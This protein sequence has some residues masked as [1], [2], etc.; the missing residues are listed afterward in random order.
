MIRNFIR[1]FT[2]KVLISFI[3]R[4]IIGISCRYNK[5]IK[6]NQQYIYVANHNSHLDTACILCALSPQELLST[7]PV[8][9]ADYFGKNKLT[10][11]LSEYFLNA[12]LIRRNKENGGE[13]PIEKMDKL[14]KQGKSLIIFPEGSRGEP[15]KFQAFKLGV[16]IL[17]AK[18]PHIPFLPIYMNG[19]GKALPKGEGVVLPFVGSVTFGK[20]RYINKDQSLEEITDFIKSSILELTQKVR[21]A[22]NL[23]TNRDTPQINLEPNNPL[24]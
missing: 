9:A 20:P 24:N 16:S 15:E 5:N 7:H 17:L 2:W 19:L 13:N 4:W 11:F 18:N 12:C 21:N 10:T 6:E 22:A 23:S 8:A 1:L 14:L 3:I